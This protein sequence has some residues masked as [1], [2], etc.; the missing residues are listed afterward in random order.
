MN[1]PIQENGNEFSSTSKKK[2]TSLFSLPSMIHTSS[3]FYRYKKP[4]PSPFFSQPRLP[5]ARPPRLCGDRPELPLPPPA[6]APLLPPRLF[7][8]VFAKTLVDASRENLGDARPRRRGHAST[9][10][11]AL[12]LPE[13][14]V[15]HRAGGE[16]PDGRPRKH[17]ADDEEI[18]GS[19]GGGVIPGVV[20]PTGG[21]VLVGSGG[22]GVRCSSP[23][24][25]RA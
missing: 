13:E 17:G 18:G 24:R 6:L 20:V 12:A 10:P 22:G 15:E 4:R 19:G 16:P 9:S 2:I 8:I 5:L 7:L 14:D 23:A 21:F 25:G 1:L 3:L 11:L